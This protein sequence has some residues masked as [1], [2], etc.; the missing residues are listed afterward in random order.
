MN[1]VAFA[2]YSGSGKTTLVES[3]IP[4]LKLRGLRVSV[5]KHAHHSFDIDQPGKDT[6]RHRQAGA[7][8]VVVASDNRL[9]LIREFE[10]PTALSVH[11]LIAELY[12]GVD[13][14]LVEGFKSSDLLKVEVWRA[15]SGKPARYPDDDFV[16]A[17]A[18]DSPDR[19]PETTLRPVLDLNDADAVAA[20]LIENHER[21][22]YCAELYA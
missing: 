12:E 22:V 15:D 16:V 3:L 14:V 17:I 5:V 7:F 2:G 11:H 1:V 19:L 4:A 10:Q 18:T 8:E 20:W 21:F 9:A 13:W 6:Y